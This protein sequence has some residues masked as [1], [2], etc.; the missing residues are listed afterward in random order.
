MRRKQQTAALEASV[1]ALRDENDALRGR[2]LGVEEVMGELRRAA[3][4]RAHSSAVAA[5]LREQTEALQRCRAACPRTF[6]SA[7]G[8]GE[9]GGGSGSGGGAG[10]GE[11]V[12]V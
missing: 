11:A 5:M 10:G 1:R 9:G 12:G 3:A 7:A 4:A 6:G 8:G 2:V